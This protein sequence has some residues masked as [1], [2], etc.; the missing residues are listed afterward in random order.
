MPLARIREKKSGNVLVRDPTS[1]P[2]VV[3]CYLFQET[4]LQAKFQGEFPIVT[5]KTLDSLGRAVEKPALRV[6]FPH[7][8]SIEEPVGLLGFGSD[9]RCHVLLPA[10]VVGPVHCRVFAQ[11]NSGPHVWVVDDTS[12]QGTGVQDDDTLRDS[13]SKVVLGRRQA[14]RGLRSLTIGP[15]R[16]QIRPPT[17]NAEIARRDDWFSLNKA[18]PV[19]QSML[20]RQ[21][22]GVRCNWLRKEFIAEGGN[23]KVYKYMETNTALYIAVKEQKVDDDKHKALALKEIQ[24]EINF[25]KTLRHVS[26]RY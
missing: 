3:A 4:D 18:I 8:Q 5:I 11:L 25:M 1:E 9:P 7:D 12:T 2:V 6:T 15:Y 14:A 20:D 16:F 19:T 22:G 26:C 13:S 23:A 17:S 10:G 24:K 21:L